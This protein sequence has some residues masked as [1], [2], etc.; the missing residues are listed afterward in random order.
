VNATVLSG[1]LV[2]VVGLASPL[3]QSPDPVEVYKTYLAAFAKADSLDAILPFYTKELRTGL[4]KMPKDQQANYMK[5]Q[6]GKQRL[7]ELTVTKRTVDAKNASFE[8]TA[9]T[10]DGRSISGSATLVK[11]GNDWKID[12]EAWALPPPRQ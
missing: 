12:D 7:T 10:G 2:M 1:V 9:K 6:V 4:G 5:M 8:M 3:A 11:E